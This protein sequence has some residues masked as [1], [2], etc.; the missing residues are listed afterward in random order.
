MTTTE[1][2]SFSPRAAEELL[3]KLSEVGYDA[4][5]LDSELGN[6]DCPEGCYVEPDG[7]CSHGY[8]SA[9]MTLGVV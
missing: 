1:Q 4:G 5:C 9:G 3:E 7:H 6:T 2:T 8:L